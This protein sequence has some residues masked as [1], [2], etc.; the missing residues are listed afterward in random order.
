MKPEDRLQEARKQ[1]QLAAEC[2]AVSEN[3]EAAIRGTASVTA[4][5]ASSIRVQ[6]EQQLMA[7]AG[8][9]LDE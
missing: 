4:A 7:D 9:G 6:R 1:L 8:G 3:Q 2:G 5:L